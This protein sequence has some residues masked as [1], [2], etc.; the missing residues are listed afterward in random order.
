MNLKRKINTPNKNITF[1]GWF[2]S[3]I[4][5]KNGQRQ[6]QPPQSNQK[7]RTNG[8][9]ARVF[10][11][12]GYENVVCVCAHA[13]HS[14]PPRSQKHCESSLHMNFNSGQCATIY[15]HQSVCLS[16]RSHTPYWLTLI[17][18]VLVRPV[19]ATKWNEMKSSKS[20]MLQRWR[21]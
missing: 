21:I 16:T 13:P 5:E 12:H 11:I 8:R 10:P 20:T 17:V 19:I 1:V 18:G 3:S 14:M 6:R 2:F 7:E 15:V 9:K 4:G